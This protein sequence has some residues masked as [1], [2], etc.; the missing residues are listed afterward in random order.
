MERA[1]VW[2]ASVAS[3]DWS[4]LHTLPTWRQGPP[5]PVTGYFL[6]RGSGTQCAVGFTHHCYTP[7]GG[8]NGSRCSSF[9]PQVPTGP[10]WG[11]C[12]QGSPHPAFLSKP[13]FYPSLPPVHTTFLLTP[14]PSM[15]SSAPWEGIPEALLPPPPP[16]SVPAQPTSLSLGPFPR[17]R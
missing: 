16:R 7:A 3:D 4:A 8:G 10:R 11:G 17:S 1:A 2:G 12:S 9:Q 15:H 5:S 6:S 14:P 13:T